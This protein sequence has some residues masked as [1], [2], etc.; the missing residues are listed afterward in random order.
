MFNLKRRLSNLSNHNRRGG[1]DKE[2]SSSNSGKNKEKA[3]TST[4]PPPTAQE[5]STLESPTSSRR[6]V[7]FDESKNTL[8][9]TVHLNDMSQEEKDTI[10]ITPQEFMENKSQTTT[11][12]R[13]MMANSNRSIHEV[14]DICIRG[15]GKSV[16]APPPSSFCP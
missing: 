8:C 16:R 7:K 3:T 5:E 2:Q 9:D 10:W 6:K 14:D 11:T 4:T 13:L 12:L 1:G 15:L